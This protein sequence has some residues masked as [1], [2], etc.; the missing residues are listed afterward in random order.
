MNN[1]INS[2]LDLNE[3]K[4]TLDRY[5]EAESEDVI[6]LDLLMWWKSSGSKYKILSL[7]AGDVLSIPVTTVA[8]K[9]SFS[10]VRRVLDNF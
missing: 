2:Q 3:N 10:T 6:D 8:S 4:S 9:S 5:L 1:F 7:M